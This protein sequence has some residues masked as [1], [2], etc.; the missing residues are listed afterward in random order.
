MQEFAMSSPMIASQHVHDAT[1]G[2]HA[3]FHDSCLWEQEW[4]SDGN[5][6]SYTAGQVPFVITETPAASSFIII[7][8]LESNN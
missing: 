4:L 7:F 5:T 2:S 3:S 6:G 1:V 8:S